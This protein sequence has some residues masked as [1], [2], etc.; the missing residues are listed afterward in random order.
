M[1][2]YHL[3]SIILKQKQ[4][5][6]KILT[7]RNKK[8]IIPNQ[9]YNMAEILAHNTVTDATE[10]HEGKFCRCGRCIALVNSLDTTH[11]KIAA[12]ASFPVD[13]LDDYGG[14]HLYPGES[15]RFH[16]DSTVHGY[17]GDSVRAETGIIA[18]EISGPLV[19]VIAK[20]PSLKTVFDSNQ[21]R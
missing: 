21:A 14:Y 13:N 1:F 2:G 5:K 16:D 4:Y 8:S 7:L 10:F 15:I 3:S 17:A 20:N 6:P 19:R 11:D 9:A 12:A 18:S